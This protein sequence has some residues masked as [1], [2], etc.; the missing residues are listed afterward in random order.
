MR[1]VS[2][3]DRLQ[4][5]TF[6]VKPNLLIFGK[7][8]EVARTAIDGRLS[9][10]AILDQL[11]YFDRQVLSVLRE[12]G[13]SPT[14]LRIRNRKISSV[15][16]INFFKIVNLVRELGRN[17]LIRFVTLSPVYS[18][19]DIDA[20]YKVEEPSTPWVDK[21]R[22]LG[23]T[24]ISVKSTPVS[25]GSGKGG[26]NVPESPEQNNTSTEPLPVSTSSTQRDSFPESV[27]ESSVDSVL[28]SPSSENSP[29]TGSLQLSTGVTGDVT[30]GYSLGNQ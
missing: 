26:E 19:G 7:N 23:S 22:E 9:E 8:S 12:R 16:L 30:N 25:T 27:S 1:N 17:V 24:V 2:I 14:S 10:E 4:S 13:V 5:V 18:Y 21:G 29:S 15:Q 28:I 6:E 3:G 11:F 20:I